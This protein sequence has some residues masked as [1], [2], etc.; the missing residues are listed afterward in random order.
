[1]AGAQ[2][3]MKRGIVKDLYCAVDSSPQQLDHV[4]LPHLRA[5]TRNP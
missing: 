3:S 5:A 1:M 4:L 2:A